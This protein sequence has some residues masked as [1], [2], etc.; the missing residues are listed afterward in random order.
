MSPGA[1][2]GRGHVLVAKAAYSSIQS[3]TGG[4][5]G[6]AKHKCDDCHSTIPVG[7]L[8]FSCRSG[9]SFHACAPCAATR[10]PHA[11]PPPGPVPPP[12]RAGSQPPAVGRQSSSDGR[13]LC[14]FGKDCYNHEPD[15]R[16]KFWHPEVEEG[17]SPGIRSACKFG[18][19]C[20]RKNPDHL[21]NFA[22]PG[23]RNYRIGLVH[24]R[25]GQHP[26][27]DNLWQLFQYY[28]PDE[29][30]H[31]SQDE[32]KDLLQAVGHMKGRDN[33]EALDAGQAWTDAQGPLHGYINFRQL[34]TWTKEFLQLDFPLGL[35]SGT[36]G[37]RACRF[38]MLSE[39]GPRCSCPSF[40]PAGLGGSFSSTALCECGHK[41]S[42]HRSEF[43]MRTFSQYLQ[44][45]SRAS[46]WSAGREGLVRIED[47]AILQ[48]MQT[49]LDASH[50]ATDNWTRDRGCSL[51]GVNGCALPCASKNRKPVP[52]GYK[53]DY[54]FRNQ[55]QDLWQ[56][57]CLVRTAIAE[58]ISRECELP[59][60][61][62]QVAT[63]GKALE[64]EPDE[65]LNEWY[66]FHGT[67]PDKSKSICAS[68]FRLA[69]AGKG[70]TWK[71][72]GKDT[73]TPL[74]GPGVY[75]A[76]M[77]TKSDEY[78]ERL[79]AEGWPT[80]AIIPTDGAELYTILVC[81]VVGGRANV[82]TTNEIEVDKLRKDVFEGS[83]NSVFGDRVALLGKP[84]RE[85]VVYDKDQCYPEFLLVYRRRYG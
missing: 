79:P 73:G 28:D 7:Q 3:V 67:G 54:A 20:Y 35:E 45:D 12:A 29:S 16:Q 84:Y 63:S 2:C 44:D 75:F 9:C 83:Y 55:N 65:S 69:M 70:A 40:Q 38:R 17:V 6:T 49:L 71:E 14:Q 19:R 66:L 52:T 80:E 48:Q 81:R 27:F 41:A 82:V 64:V 50:K 56:K 8:R 43:A 15:H 53:L 21:E 68:N 78:S 76:E 4:F 23:D 42:M 32:F 30:G 77:V 11:T 85:V 47:E 10:V 62:R 57:Y 5:L 1:V 22:H 34:V 26:E 13:P 31:L 18:S 74:Y 61:L 59:H 72:P 60:E 36:G 37:Q 24:F 33:G 51:H 58:E 25:K 39:D 46:H